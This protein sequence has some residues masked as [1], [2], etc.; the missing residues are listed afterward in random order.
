M[1]HSD[2]DHWLVQ[3]ATIRRIC[4]ISIAILAVTVLAE[5]IIPIKG[6]FGIDN[7]LGFGAVFGFIACLLMVLLA[8]FLGLFLKRE[9]NY[10]SEG[11][12]HD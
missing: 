4:W 2:S 12:D 10:Y 6:Y 9:E 1:K 8:K 11:G 7:W 3:E 5:L